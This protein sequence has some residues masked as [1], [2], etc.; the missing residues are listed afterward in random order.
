MSKIIK[1]DLPKS[2]SRFAG[3]DYGYEIYL[4]QVKDKIDFN[5]NEKIIIEFPEHVEGV[6]ISFIQGFVREI[7]ENISKDE[8]DDYIEIKS[9]SDYLTKKILENIKF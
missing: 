8:I 3:N 4:N 1:L 2:I 5:K 6:A 9:S 7:L